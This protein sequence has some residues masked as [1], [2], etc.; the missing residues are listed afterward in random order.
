MAWAPSPAIWWSQVGDVLGDVI[1]GKVDASTWCGTRAMIASRLAGLTPRAGVPATTTPAPTTR[2]TTTSS[3][4]RAAPRTVPAPAASP[5]P[6]RRS[7]HAQVVGRRAGLRHEPVEQRARGADE[8]EP[9]QQPDLRAPLI[10]LWRHQQRADDRDEHPEHD[11]PD[12]A[13]RDGLGVGDHEEQEDQDLGREVTTTRQKSKPQ[14]GCER[15]VRGHA[16]AR[17]GE[18]R[19]SRPRSASQNA[20]RQ[21][22][23]AQAPGDEQAADED[24]RVG[25]QHPPGIERRPPEVERLDPRLPRTRKATTRPMFDGLKTCVPRYLM[26]YLVRSE[27]AGHAREDH[28]SRRCSTARSRWRADDAQDEGHAAAGEHRAGRPHEHRVDRKVSVDL[29]DRAGQDRRQDLRDADLGSRSAT[30]PRTWMVMTTAATWRRGS[31]MLG[32]TSG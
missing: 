7:P 18:Q 19:R 28:T 20:R 29:D 27:N 23:E 25:E 3:A 4:T 31:R 14:T 16:M 9:G 5:A 13:G 26:T 11:P 12:L 22:E 1:A 15:P 32:S 21:A 30:W 17:P 10:D 2:T 6:R 24:D 8:D